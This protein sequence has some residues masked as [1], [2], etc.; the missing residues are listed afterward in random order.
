MSHM[1]RHG[2]RKNR[3][4][5]YDCTVKVIKKSVFVLETINLDGGGG[6]KR[7]FPHLL[8]QPLTHRNLGYFKCAF[9]CPEQGSASELS[10]IR[11]HRHKI[12][13]K[14]KYILF[15]WCEI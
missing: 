2:S 5:P 12:Q 3:M 9:N 10:Y 7:S 4:R 1:T 14:L 15:Y 11:C 8:V 6:G 13:Q